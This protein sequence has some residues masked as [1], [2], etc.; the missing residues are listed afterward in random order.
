[1]VMSRGRFASLVAGVLV[2]GVFIAWQ[3]AEG[4]QASDVVAS[5]GRAATQPDE[6]VAEVGERGFT[7]A[8]VDQQA[9]QLD[10]GNFQGMQLS[11]ALYEARRQTLEGLIAEQLLESEAASRGVSR[12]ELVEAEIVSKVEPVT[13]A[14]VEAWFTQN[15]QRVGN[16]ALD[17]VRAQIR[18]LLEQEKNMVAGRAF[19]NTLREATSVR[20]MLEP[21]RMDIRIASNEPAKGPVDAP[22]QIVEFSDFQ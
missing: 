3:L 4:R 21:P 7:L 10:A 22:I 6:V 19:V 17:Q 9:M 2:V 18:G 16:A 12:E 15:P 1:M 13:E 20:V 11:Q 8:E 5:T 14:D